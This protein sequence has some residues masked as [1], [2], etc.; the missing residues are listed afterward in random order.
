LS[1]EVKLCGLSSKI[2]H[3]RC[4]V[5]EYSITVDV[6]WGEPLKGVVETIALM[7]P[8]SKVSYSREFGSVTLRIKGRMIGIYSSGKI[9]FCAH[10]V[11]DARE[12][13]EYVKD[14]ISKAKEKIAREGVP[15]QGRVERWTRMSALQLYK[16]LPKTNCRKCGELTC[17]A[18][19]IKVL[20][21]EKKLRECKPLGELENEALLEGLKK[22]L[23]LSALETLGWG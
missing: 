9:S 8:P 15:D 17:L 14:L 3:G 18:F 6:N 11:D 1:V 16:F 19:A 13:V 22:E 20:N 7:F 10:N 5:G 23:G 21:G 4:P 2:S 12:V